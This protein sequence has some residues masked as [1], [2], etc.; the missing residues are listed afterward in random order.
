MDEKTIESSRH[1]GRRFVSDLS[2]GCAYRRGMPVEISIELLLGGL[3]IPGFIE[4]YA[5]DN[6]VTFTIK[7][8][9]FSTHDMTWPVKAA[10]N[11]DGIQP[12]L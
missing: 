6:R 1:E 3:R 2:N 8:S 11:T 12:R 9:P 7:K 5:E 10:C 4:Y